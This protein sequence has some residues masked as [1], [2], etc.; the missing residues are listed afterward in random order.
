MTP[1]ESARDALLRSHTACMGR[2]VIV[3]AGEANLHP[4]QFQGAGDHVE[5]GRLARAV[6]TNDGTDSAASRRISTSSTA[7]RAPNRGV[8][9]LHLSS[10]T[11]PRPRMGSPGRG[12]ND[13]SPQI[14]CGRKHH[15][16]DE[17]QAE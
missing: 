9:P 15:E 2:P 16:S 3:L 11:D 17:D 12:L 8:T 10:A 5:E 7:T 14:P 6:G 1:L 4:A 13:A